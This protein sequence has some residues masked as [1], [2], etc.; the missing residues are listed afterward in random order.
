MHL[1]R[2]LEAYSERNTN[3][4]TFSGNCEL[5]DV[6]GDGNYHL[7]IADVKL[8]GDTRSKLRIYK[9]TTAK[10]LSLPDLPS[11]VISFY[12]DQVEPRIPGALYLILCFYKFC[13]VFVG[14]YFFGQQD[15]NS[16]RKISL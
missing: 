1:S 4:T 9:G 13:G 2:W 14:K 15:T 10:D 3:I 16:I 6:T 8:G 7:V 5:A 12:T 11:S